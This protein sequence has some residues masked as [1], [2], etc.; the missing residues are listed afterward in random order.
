[1]PE[2]GG[3]VAAV[4]IL[5]L[6]RILAFRDK[7]LNALQALPGEREHEGV[8]GIK[9]DRDIDDGKN[10]KDRTRA[11]GA[12]L[13]RIE[14]D[15]EIVV[16]DRH[17]APIAATCHLR[18]RDYSK[19]TTGCKGGQY[20]PEQGLLALTARVNRRLQRQ[21]RSAVPAYRTRAARSVPFIGGSRN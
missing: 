10:V 18:R 9:R 15:F 21:L 7:G 2:T 13:Q 17:A 1:M 20:M 14:Q 8:D 4:G 3:Y 19:A 5:L 16:G 11:V 12:F 6:L